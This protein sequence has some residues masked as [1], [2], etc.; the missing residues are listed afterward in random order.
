MPPL[1]LSPPPSLSPS[2]LLF[3]DPLLEKIPIVVATTPGEEPQWTRVLPFE[4]LMKVA[5]I[6]LSV[7]E[8]EEE[9]LGGKY[10]SG[11]DKRTGRVG[12]KTRKAA[13]IPPQKIPHSRPFSSSST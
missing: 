6:Y 9:E 1:S 8:E 2:T 3:R 7:F 5:N 10:S 12:E 4:I 11:R 13:T